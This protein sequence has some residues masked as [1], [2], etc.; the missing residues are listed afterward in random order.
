VDGL[1][2][3]W[4][5]GLPAAERAALHGMGNERRYRAGST[6]FHEGDLSDWVILVTAGRVKISSG[7]RDGKEVVLTICGPGELLGELSAIDAN[8]RSATA[9]AID[10]VD[11]QIVTGEEFRVFLAASPMASLAFLRSLSGRLRD[12]DRRRVEFVGLD[13][14]G[15]VATQVVELAE[16]YGVNRDDGST[17]VDIPLSQDELAGLTGASREAVGKALQLFRR[18]GWIQTARRSITVLNVDALRS[19]AT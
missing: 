9:T 8:P 19:R 12:S 7:T 14:V 17:Q 6:L 1:L 4:F 2:R 13:S 10:A 18:R 15:R 16:R 3:A 11:A 5:A